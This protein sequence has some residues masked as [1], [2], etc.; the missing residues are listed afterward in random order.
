[1]IV[2]L[3]RPHQTVGIGPG[4]DPAAGPDP[5]RHPGAGHVPGG[6]ALRSGLVVRHPHRN[7]ARPEAAQRA[8]EQAEWDA[9]PGPGGGRESP[10]PLTQA[11]RP[12][13]LVPET[14]PQRIGAAVSIERTLVLIKPDG[15]T[16]NLTGAIIARI[17]AKGYTLA[18]AQE[19]RRLAGT[20]GA[21]L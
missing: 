21:A 5:D 16:R 2:G 4:L 1:M 14:R 19:G 11:A 3:R 13:R 9:A 6:R 12:R 18:E 7:P 20:A 8:R 15:V 17:E 10:V